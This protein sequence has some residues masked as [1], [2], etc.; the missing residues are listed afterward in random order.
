MPPSCQ[1]IN[2]WNTKKVKINDRCV[3]TS[4][5]LKLVSNRSVVRVALAWSMTEVLD[6]AIYGFYRP[7]SHRSHLSLCPTNCPEKTKLHVV[8]MKILNPTTRTD[9]RKD[10]GEVKLM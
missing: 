10:F 7:M 2:L 5:E 4:G 1:S 3:G 9:K 6:L 8:Q